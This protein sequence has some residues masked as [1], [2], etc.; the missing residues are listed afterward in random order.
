MPVW[1][2][3]PFWLASS[4]ASL[5]GGLVA[6]LTF[7]LSRSLERERDRREDVI[8][9]EEAERRRGER[10]GS[11]LRQKCARLVRISWDLDTIASHARDKSLPVEDQ[12]SALASESFEVTS[13]IVMISPALAATAH[14]LSLISTGLLDA[15]DGSDEEF[16]AAERASG[17]AYS[18]FLDMAQEQLA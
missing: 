9:R 1:T 12:W 7:R 13:E 6:Y 2:Q 17:E 11:E 3:L 4:R 16:E 15:A 14:S 10:W 18:A 5:Q 8:R